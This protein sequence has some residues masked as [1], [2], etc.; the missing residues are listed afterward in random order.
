MAERTILHMDLDAF[1]CAVEELRDP[2]LKGKPFVV[3]G[4]PQGRGVVSSASYAARKFGIHS[5]MPTAQALRLCPTLTVISARHGD[6]AAWAKK[7]MDILSDETP[8]IER[9]SID[10]A[11]LDVSQ[12]RES[13][14][15][16]ALRLQ[17]EIRGRLGLPTSW[18]V[19]SNKLVAKIATEVGK[20][21]GCVVVPPGEEAAFLAPLPVQMLWGVGPK[22]QEK[23]RQAGIETIGQLAGM[24]ERALRS[25][26]GSRGPEL[27]ARARGEDER[28][29]VQHHRR[30]SMSV[31]RTFA[32]DQGDREL[33]ESVLLSMAEELGRRLRER[34]MSAQVVR[35]K[36]R[37]PDFTT[38]TRQRR[39][40]QPTDLD[41]EIFA[42]GL[43]LFEGLWRS[44][45]KV[46]LIGLGVAELGAFPRQL[47]LFDGT[48]QLERR[49]M[50]AVDRIR[51]KYGEGAV[52]R[53]RLMR[54]KEG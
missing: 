13:G 36:L 49:L 21:E 25:L 5:A 3:G 2:N 35:L 44:G 24:P 37:W 32:R 16:I 27:A 38:M 28:P 7:V 42:A 18:G 23:L 33:L 52:R 22:T 54:K 11:F 4:S 8:L 30:K 41:E 19:A 29:V 48:W 17:A 34:D 10:E 40:A 45:R 53:A 39:L 6:Y 9:I 26:F 14:R 43:A 1:F 12:V 50:E 20:P 46:R 15:Q 31:E 51:D 47:E